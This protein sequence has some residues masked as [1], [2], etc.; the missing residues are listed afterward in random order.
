MNKG[1]SLGIG[2][3][4]IST[5]LDL[6]PGDYGQPLRWRKIFGYSALMGMLFV[7]PA[8]LSNVIFDWIPMFDG[9]VKSFFNWSKYSPVVFVGLGNFARILADP[10][11]YASIGNM[12]FFLIANLILMLPPLICT[13]VLFRIRSKKTQY[14]YRVLLCLQMVIPGLVFTLMWI[15]ILGYDFGAINNLLDHLG[16]NRILFLGD[17]QLIKWTIILTGIPFVSANAVLIYLGGLNGISDSIWEAAT[18]DGIGPVSRFTKLE[19]PL[20]IGQFKLNLIGVL[21]ASI[22]AYGQQ[23]VFYNGSVHNGIMTP[24]LLMY[25]KAFPN[26]GAPDYGY[27]YAL[28]LLLFVVSLTI[29]LV[30]L[31]LVKSE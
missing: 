18:L 13:I 22:T 31:K 11:F 14:A 1:Y 12:I 6:E 20:L 17:S 8:V 9:I 3:K 5:L 4:I 16:M 28:G 29:S 30:T 15:F 10:E 2:R 23:L 25:F 19:F 21:G 26:T 27:A 24:G 7:M